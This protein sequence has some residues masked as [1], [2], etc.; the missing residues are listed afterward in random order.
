MN[1]NDI[2]DKDLCAMKGLVDDLKKSVDKARNKLSLDKI[3]FVLS[4]VLQTLTAAR[5]CDTH[6]E[7]TEERENE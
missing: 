5:V 6:H 1:T 4:I 3:I 2:I 7:C